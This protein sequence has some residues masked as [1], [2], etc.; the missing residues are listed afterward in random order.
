MSGIT[1][2]LELSL[3][4]RSQ[5]AG[6]F[7]SPKRA[8]HPVTWEAEIRPCGRTGLRSLGRPNVPPID[9]S[10]MLVSRPRPWWLVIWEP[11]PTKAPGPHLAAPYCCYIRTV[12]FYFRPYICGFSRPWRGAGGRLRPGTRGSFIEWDKFETRLTWDDVVV[13]DGE[14]FVIGGGGVRW[15]PAPDGGRRQWWMLRHARRRHAAA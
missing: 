13:F 8:G 15:A 7:W 4:E 11:L 9:C 1:D 12:I 6:R 2:Q 10:D 5:A 14:E 3:P